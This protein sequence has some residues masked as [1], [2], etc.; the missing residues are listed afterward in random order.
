MVPGGQSMVIVGNTAPVTIHPSVPAPGPAADDRGRV[1][2]VVRVGVRPRL[3]ALFV[4]RHEMATLRAALSGAGP[5]TV[6]AVQG[7]R[8]VGKSQLASAFAQ[9]CEL[10]GWPVV[11]WVDAATR[12][13]AVGGV[14][15]LADALGV[16]VE[17]ASPEED[18]QRVVEHLNCTP[19]G[20][21]LVVFDN[22]EDPD[23]L[24]G[25][26]PHPDAARVVVTTTRATTTLGVSVRV[27]VYSVEK[28]VA[29][30]TAR[31]KVDDPAGAAGVAE[32]LG[33][34]PV[35]VTQAATAILTLGHTYATYRSA[36]ASS[37]LDQV[38]FREPGDSY[39]DIVGA[40]LRM[41][42]TA[43]LGRLTTASAAQGS[44]AA[45]VLDA[46]SLLADS[47][48]PRHWLY[49]LA[50][51]EQTARQVVGALVTASL[52]TESADSDRTM[53]T[54][55]RLIARVIR[56]DN[57]A[58]D[59]ARDADQHATRVLS[60][61]QPLNLDGYAAQRA[62]TTLLASQLLALLAQD[63]SRHLAQTPAVLSVEGMCVYWAN[64]LSDPYTAI[65]LAEYVSI[66]EQVLGPDH[67]DTLASRNNLAG[68]YQAAGDLGQAIPLYEAT[69]TDIE[70]VLGPDH[71]DTLASR[72]NLAYAYESAGDLGQAIPL[73]EATLTDMERV[74]GPDHPATLTSR[75]NLAYAYQAAGDL[76]QA[77]PLYEATLTDRERVLGPDHPDT[78]ASRNNLAY[79]YQA[80][81]DLGQA[82]PLYEATLTDR[83]RVL[84][85]D[86]PATLTSRN[87]LAYA[88]QSAGDLGQAIPLYE[89]TLT[90]LERVLGPDHPSTLTSRN[91]LAYAYQS[92]GDLGQAIPLY[93]ATLT[94]MERVLGPDHPATLTSRN[95]LAYAQK[96]MRLQKRRGR[97]ASR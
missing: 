23:D 1:G 51:D 20:H 61:V 84:G 33:F 41:A 31:T 15:A 64:E 92:A 30:L 35:A 73:C 37:V 93:E 86:H 27:G 89:A 38:T 47:G 5:V 96:E 18:A 39:P 60:A 79:A 9:E 12:E 65:G 3:A 78:L 2:G 83:E 44:C 54:V 43:E 11:A 68:A 77:I 45:A 69:L 94:D 59:R 63:H 48:V 91:N 7:M 40:A 6:C 4:D 42:L 76:G 81:G 36:L 74:L 21:R 75:N 72:N 67:P 80:A 28:A 17:G 66:R 87:N 25:L 71:P 13:Q 8:G 70:R 58:A 19:H 29:Y 14:A 52:L 46:V 32:D 57:H 56:E 88:Y 90:N 82:I 24:A 62:A 55:H 22:V 95:N 16:A 53:V 49:A 10:A 85:P 97:G 26:I 50:D 34:L